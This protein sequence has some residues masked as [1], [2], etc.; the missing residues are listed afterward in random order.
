MYKDIIVKPENI[1]DLITLADTHTNR[2]DTQSDNEGETLNLTDFLVNQLDIP[3][4]IKIEGIFEPEDT[5]DHLNQYKSFVNETC[6]VSVSPQSRMDLET[7]ANQN[8]F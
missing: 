7:A 8:Q 4:P 2:L 5:N 1:S 3:I 6:L